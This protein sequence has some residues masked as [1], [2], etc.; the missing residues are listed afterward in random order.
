M[1]YGPKRFAS[2]AL[3]ALVIALFLSLSAI[4]AFYTDYLWFDALGYL[5]LFL[6]VFWSKVIL[7]LIGAVLFALFALA[8]L[9]VVSRIKGDKALKEDSAKGLRFVLFGVFS[10]VLGFTL[11]G[12][13]Q[14][15]LTYL[16]Q[17]PFGLADPVFGKDIGFYVFTLPFYTTLWGYL[18]LAVLFGFVLTAIAYLPVLKGAFRFPSFPHTPFDQ[19]P[20][21]PPKDL[22]LGKAF[23]KVPRAVKLH[24][25]LFVLGLF[26]LLAVRNWLDRYGIL[27]SRMGAV[28]G[29]GYTDLN[30]TLPLLVLMAGLSVVAGIAAVAYLTLGSGQGKRTRRTVLVGILIAYVILLVLGKG[31]VPALV[32]NIIVSP[33]EI[34]LET[35]YIERN[36]ELTRYAY[37]IDSVDELEFPAEESITADMLGM[38]EQTVDNIRLLDWR[39]LLDSYKQLQEIRLYY[40]F[41]DIDIDRYTIN[42]S[43]RQVML[44]PREIRQSQ[45]PSQAQ[46]WLNQHSVYTH[47]Y[48]VVMSPVNTIDAQGMPKFLLKDIPPKNIAGDPALDVRQPG[49]YYGEHENEYILTRTQT[50]EFDYPKGDTNIYTAYAGKGGV[51]IDTPLKRLMFA[52]R[53]Q[54]YKLLVSGQLK[55][56]TRI[57]FDRSVQRRIGKVMPFLTLDPDPYLVVADGR[58]WWIQDAY[59]V[60][61]SFPYSEPFQGIN[62]L[63]N[64]VKAVVDAY[65]GTVTYYVMDTEDPVIRTYMNLFPTQFRLF[66]EMPDPLKPHVRYPELLFSVQAEMYASY[67]MRDPTVFYNKE[68]L[69]NLPKQIYGRGEQVILDPYYI[70]MKLPDMDREEF[71]MLLPFTPQKKDNMIAWMAANSDS[72][73]GR[74]VVYK[75]P[76]EKMV[77]GPMQIEA[78]IDQ[79]SEISQEITLWSQQG[80]SVIRGNLLVLPIEN[81]LLYVEPLFIIAEKSQM[82][83]L[84]RVIISDGKSIVM[85]ETLEK[86]FA[87]LFG[88]TTPRGSGRAGGTGETGAAVGDG[89]LTRAQ[90]AYEAVQ[91]A[92]RRGDWAGIGTSLAELGGIIA[93]LQE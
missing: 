15:V 31:I 53:F 82:P 30:V 69:W 52:I 35:P 91:D 57:M 84:K 48:G 9:F 24:L 11:S 36:I 20:A 88:A 18:L 6:T 79:D 41:I 17:Q 63:R 2:S 25:G 75:F 81:S 50:Q 66:A 86:A 33:N 71:M 34:T 67:H 77:F 19:F 44:S 59:T 13:W 8:N 65:D 27:L 42:G 80:S 92:M 32:Q 47:G 58:L 12:A 54:D 4:A 43:Y 89:L 93:E 68:D 37:G 21:R 74:I 85:E 62:Y 23:Q 64:S 16:A 46:T 49:I 78:R 90:E 14:T 45:L 1:A 38:N 51:V 60:A 72:D 70:I 76:K 73:Y 55:D 26:L 40:D 87:T 10:F 56:D 29:A 61:S 22:G 3:I 7:F 83:E 39:P 28:Y 5:P